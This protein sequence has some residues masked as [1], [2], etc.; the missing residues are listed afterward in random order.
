MTN[1]YVN[2]ELSAELE[3][4]G[5]KAIVFSGL[6][7]FGENLSI[8]QVAKLKE[9]MDTTKGLPMVPAIT[10]FD[11][12][13]PDNARLIWPEGTTRVWTRATVEVL[14]MWQAGMD[15]RSYVAWAVER[16]KLD[17]KVVEELVK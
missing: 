2:A 4:L 14:H 11:L 12:L 3:A 8:Q 5:V 15:W 9:N 10:I 13:Y 17:G 16:R 7:C 1:I 6:Q